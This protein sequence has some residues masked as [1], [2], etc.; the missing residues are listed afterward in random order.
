MKKVIVILLVLSM[1]TTTALAGSIKCIVIGVDD[2]ILLEG[3]SIITLECNGSANIMIGKEVK[4][5]KVKVKKQV[6]EG[7]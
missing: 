5:K 4:V 6:I 2:A 7:C 3:Q 1:V